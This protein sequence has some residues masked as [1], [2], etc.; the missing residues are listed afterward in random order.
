MAF[1]AMKSSGFVLETLSGLAVEICPVRMITFG[2][3]K[4]GYSWRPFVNLGE[5]VL[6]GSSSKVSWPL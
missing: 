5:G 1:K 6:P 4:V 3:V 2:G